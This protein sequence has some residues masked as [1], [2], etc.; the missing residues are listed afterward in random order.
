[1]L[2]IQMRTYE[3][4]KYWHRELDMQKILQS[5]VSLGVT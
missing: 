5:I 2:A 1:M 3:Y 4:W